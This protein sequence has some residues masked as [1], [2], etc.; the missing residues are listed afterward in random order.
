META[1]ARQLARLVFNAMNS[2]DP[3]I[4]GN[5]LA[6]DAVFDFP[7]AGEMHGIRRILV[8]FKVLFKKYPRL[9]FTVEDIIIDGE[10][11]CVIWRN[12]GENS[13]GQ[14]YANRGVTVITCR[15]D[16]ICFL[17]DYFKDTSF[18]ER[19]QL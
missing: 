15:D 12:K 8:F 3:A 5:H 2:R 13:S 9:V 10:R 11:A 4:L 19:Q 18:N 7:G 17:S 14:A 1:H 16:K 6:V